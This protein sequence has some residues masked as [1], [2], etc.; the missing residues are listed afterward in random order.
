MDGT[1]L[2]RGGLLWSASPRW[3]TRRRALVH[4]PHGDLEGLPQ[5]AQLLAAVPPY[6]VNE[7]GRKKWEAIT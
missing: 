3:R 5:P 1:P 6:L 4:L 2:R 7:I